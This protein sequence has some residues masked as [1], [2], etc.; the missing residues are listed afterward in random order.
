[1]PYIC[2]YVNRNSDIYCICVSCKTGV[3]PQFGVASMMDH[4]EFACDTLV[5][6]MPSIM[7][8]CVANHHVWS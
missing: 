1:M 7:K 2:F 4:F 3:L 8:V 5:W 6:I